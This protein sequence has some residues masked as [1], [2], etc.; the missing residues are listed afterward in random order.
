MRG[1]MRSARERGDVRAASFLA[2][3]DGA[4]MIILCL[5]D[6]VSLKTDL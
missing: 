2:V 4:R 6:P 5:F 1:D 3:S